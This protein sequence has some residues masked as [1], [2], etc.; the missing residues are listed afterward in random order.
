MTL[1]VVKIGTSLLRG[2]GG[3]STVEVIERL[4]SALAQ[5]LKRGDRAVLVSSGAVGLGCHRLGLETRP[6]DVVGLQAAAAIGQ[7]HLMGIYDQAMGRHGHAV[8]Q[9][10]L[11][12]SD[13]SDRRSYHSASATLHQLLD[14]QV[15]PIVNEN[16][17]VSS[18]ELRFGDNDTLSAL[19][20]TA[21][22]ADELIL[23]TDVDRL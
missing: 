9:V 17:T 11:T 22:G 1:R 21:L 12:R 19:V 20:A 3:L 7:G 8:A 2:E 23:L 10:L 16:D 5:S 4:T 15:L 14:W 13:L 18:A 6:D